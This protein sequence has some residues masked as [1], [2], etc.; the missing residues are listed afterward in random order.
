VAR[1]AISALLD[2]EPPITDPALL[3]AHLAGCAGCRAWRERA[4]EVT[5]RTRLGSAEPAPLADPAVIRALA[6]ADR[7][8]WWLSL[9]AARAGLLTVA[10]AQAVV[11][12]PVLILGS[13]RDAPMHVAHEMG[14]FDV[15]LAVGFLVA[16]WR[17][18][19]A[20]G[21]RALV[22]VAT[23]LLLLTAVID[24]L[25]GRTTLGDEAPHLIALAGWV[26]LMRAAWLTSDRD[27]GVGIR[28]VLRR[29]P[30]W[31]SPKADRL[32]AP[33]DEDERWA[34]AASS[35]Q[36][37][38][39][40]RAAPLACLALLVAAGLALLPAHAL[41]D[42]DPGSD[43][44]VNQNL[45]VDADAGVTIPQQASLGNLLQAAGTSGA[46]I[47]VAI[48]AH[49]DDLGAIM[50]LWD[51]PQTYARFL[52]IELSLAYKQRLLVVMPNGFGFNWPGHDLSAT[53]RM[54]AGIRVGSGPSAL[55]A[56]TRTAVVRIV[57]LSGAKLSLKQ[58][59]AASGGA[60]G[61]GSVQA[62]RSPTVSPGSSAQRTSG[63]SGDQM[64]GL[65]T[66]AVVLLLVA[67][68]TGRRLVARLVRFRA[69]RLERVGWALTAVIG[70][71]GAAV[72]VTVLAL[73]GGSTPAIAA[74]AS[75]PVLDPG[76][77]L[78]GPAPNFTLINQYGRPVSLRSFRG[79]VVLLAFTDSE[80]TTICPLTTSAMVD[81]QAML[82]RAGSRVALLG[83]DANPKDTSLEDV[84]S[85]TQLHGLVGRWQFVTG[86]LSALRRVWRKYGIEAQ[87]A[88]GLIS[89]TPA[90]FVIGPNG[91][92]AR[93]YLTQES[94]AAV[95]QLGQ[96]LAQE[97]SRLLPGHPRVD[98]R[99]SYA[100]IN[101]I[102]PSTAI[103]V[104][105]ADGGQVSVGPGK[106]RVLLFFATWDQEVTSLGG[107]LVALNAYERQAA[108]KRMPELTA[109][110]E[111]QVEP[112][113][114]TLPDFLRELPGRLAYPVGVDVTG[115][116]ADGYGVSALPFLEVT[117]GSGRVLW[118]WNVSVLGWPSTSVLLAH[119]RAALAYGARTGPSTATQVAR[120]LAG[121]PPALAS[122]HDQ[123]SR[124]L[125]YEGALAARLR[126][127]RG[128]PV[129]L[130]A[131]ASW[132]TPCRAEFGLLA[133]ASAA[134][135][136]KVAFLGAD[137]EDSS[138]D[139]QAFL[140]Q[141]HVS[142][143]SYQTSSA[144]LQ[145]IIPQGL[146][147]LPTT[148]FIGRNGRVVY[149]H[150][151]QYDSL[152]TLEAD[153]ANYALKGG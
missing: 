111:R 110:D 142:Y 54:L 96:L 45:F 70:V 33:L 90:L 20:H 82:G 41:A 9:S 85:Y 151:G 64:V 86:S 66:I 4:H 119:V 133:T 105:G 12:F 94:Y 131:W 75:N 49:P 145:R 144:Q 72:T 43:V 50:A 76:T 92:M 89:H 38:Q 120:D 37:A 5:R 36:G 46:P 71:L 27:G 146:E 7:R 31:Q 25:A 132:C 104:P 108:A 130:N 152:G 143:P 65:V 91:R 79:K 23:L 106:A 10:L 126:S 52:G 136:R 53:Y 55:V 135:G 95:G 56:A 87:V 107:H 137:T 77:K 29:S 32:A 149:V 69:V 26:L 100:H 24:L 67:G 11:A 62:E 60:V 58:P 97:A 113:G 122:L 2:G 51:K 39:A 18:V 48:I 115:R 19:Q 116:L 6:A 15:A 28:R 83:V 118:Y 139:A 117:G 13:D 3:E 68:Y 124:L 61:S 88:A 84:L 128:Y 1:E 30:R 112:S 78:S 73:Q 16:A 35:A 127:L 103:S 129:V 93:L 102:S 44:L 8:P 123:A 140:S 150:T 134:S 98:S 34:P 22:G 138:S 109:V 121:S 17:P 14:S 99:L 101:G 114:S 57:A 42:G 148:I 153:I 63:R 59:G 21:M 74:L 80:C 141:H 81:A 47:R 125:G 147:G 40:G